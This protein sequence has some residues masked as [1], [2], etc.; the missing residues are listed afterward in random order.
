MA[1]T[2]LPDYVAGFTPGG[3]NLGL[4]SLGACG[5]GLTVATPITNVSAFSALLINL[6]EIGPQTSEVDI[7]FYSD[8]A[9]LS[10]VTVPLSFLKNAITTTKF[11]LPVLGPYFKLAVTNNSGVGIT[12]VNPSV[13]GLVNANLSVLKAAGLYVL[14]DQQGAALGASATVNVLPTNPFSGGTLAQ[15]GK[16]KVYALCGQGSGLALQMWNGTTW[17]TIAAFTLTGLAQNDFE[18]FLPLSDWRLQI[19][20]NN[21]VATT[22]NLAV[23]FGD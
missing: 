16:A 6:S 9:G 12:S 3:A 1:F 5:A 21:A 11:V 23:V 15:P 20:N 19:T 10:P 4:L 14:I 17:D 18:V 2:D 13:A 7:T 8:P 22:F